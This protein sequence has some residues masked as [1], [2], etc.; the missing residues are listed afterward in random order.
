MGRLAGIVGPRHGYD[1][2][3]RRLEATVT[4]LSVKTRYRRHGL[5]AKLVEAAVAL[6]G[7]HGMSL[8]ASPSGDRPR[9]RLSRLVAF[10]SRFGFRMTQPMRGDERLDA[11]DAATMYRPPHN[12]DGARAR[13]IPAP[14]LKSTV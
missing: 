1:T 12:I 7:H 9:I 2:R 8:V 10:Y 4:H 11:E 13:Q 3:R 14:E 5:G 6:L